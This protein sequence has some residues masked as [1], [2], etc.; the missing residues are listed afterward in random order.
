MLNQNPYATK[1][2]FKHRPTSCCFVLGNVL[3]IR[4]TF[5]PGHLDVRLCNS[6]IFGS[7]SWLLL[8][9]LIQKSW[10]RPSW[11]LILSALRVICSGWARTAKS[12]VF[13]VPGCRPYEVM[14]VSYRDICSAFPIEVGG[15]A[16]GERLTAAESKWNGLGDKAENV[17][18]VCIS[19]AHG[20]GG[21]KSR[22][23][24]QGGTEVFCTCLCRGK[25]QGGQEMREMIIILNNLYCKHL[26]MPVFE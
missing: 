7:G 15:G 9:L 14:T 5:S 4:P 21:L 12:E 3:L 17:V 23:G 6:W 16:R 19:M 26:K 10:F 1:L 20:C 24:T 25:S 22:L 13:Y 18:M 2:Y 8:P 11:L